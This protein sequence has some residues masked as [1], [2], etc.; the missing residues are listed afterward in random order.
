MRALLDEFE[1]HLFASGMAPRMGDN[2]VLWRGVLAERVGDLAAARA[3]VSWYGPAAPQRTSCLVWFKA[4]LELSA[5]DLIVCAH[6]LEGEPPAR[7]DYHSRFS[8]IDLER[9]VRCDEQPL[10]NAL[11]ELFVLHAA[12]PCYMLDH[13]DQLGARPLSLLASPPTET[14][15]SPAE[16]PIAGERPCRVILTA[17][18]SS[19]IST[20]LQR[21]RQVPTRTRSNCTSDHS[22]A[23][24]SGRQRSQPTPIRD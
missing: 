12:R 9:A 6:E 21:K 17:T 14:R 13:I 15:R 8:M 11:T 23:Y 2:A 18:A 7:P 16:S 24:R 10:D 3:A 1:E 4:M 5:G 22:W 19:S 20:R